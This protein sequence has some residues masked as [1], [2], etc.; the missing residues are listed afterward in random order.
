MSGI[1]LSQYYYLASYSVVSSYS[2]N[3]SSLF[4][5][6]VVVHAIHTDAFLNLCDNAIVTSQGIPV[7]LQSGPMARVRARWCLVVSFHQ[8]LD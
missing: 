2:A 5:C 7:V 4:R 3:M 6:F 1:G 8:R